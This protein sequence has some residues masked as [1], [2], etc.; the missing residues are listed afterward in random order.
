MR[1]SLQ[2]GQSIVNPRCEIV[3]CLT[4]DDW[5]EGEE[6]CD[7]DLNEVCKEGGPFE[8]YCG[9]EEGYVREDPDE[10]CEEGKITLIDVRHVVK[11][12]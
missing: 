6:Q 2:P 4:G 7:D 1:F 3:R 9:C 10:V 8:Y 11:Q 5:E 12:V